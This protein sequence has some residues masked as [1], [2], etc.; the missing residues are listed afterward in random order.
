MPRRQRWQLGLVVGG[1]VVLSLAAVAAWG[2]PIRSPF[3]AASTGTLILLS[4]PAGAD[5]VVAGELRGQA[6]L[7]LDLAGGA[8][9]VEL[10]SAAGTR[11]LT[12]TVTPGATVVHHVELSAP[13]PETGILRVS[14]EPEGLTV[15]VD[16]EPRGPSPVELGGL[17]PGIREIQVAIG[18]TTLRRMVPV[19]A[20][21][22]SAVVIVA[23]TPA[24]AGPA[25]PVPAR[26]SSGW[27][28]VAAGFPVE[29]AVGGRALAMSGGRLE[30]AAGRHA[31]DIAS[32]ALGFRVRRTVVV[33]PGET[34]TVRIETPT[35]ALSVNALPWADVLIDGQPVGQTPLA[36][37][38]VPIGTREVVFRHPTYGER[39]QR[40]TVT[41]KEPARVSM[42]MQ[43]T[44]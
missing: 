17:P 38:P 1:V 29:V 6:P 10:R 31:L 33:Q 25:S 13:A 8:H 7:T 22:A 4:N 27:V 30:L 3:P 41:L 9:P 42:N 36:N 34:A 44:S 19:A 20:G 18:G 43:G 23:P 32:A 2:L 11:A 14:T 15:T 5:V 12:L 16:G 35:V 24:P 21:A 39:T 40:V 37:V 28:S 26:P